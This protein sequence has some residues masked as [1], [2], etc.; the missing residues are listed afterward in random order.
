MNW[1]TWHEGMGMWGM[2]GGVMLLLLV[3]LVVA[4]VALLRGVGGAGDASR[5]RTPLEILQARYAS[6]QISRAEF[7]EKRRDLEA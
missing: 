3:L 7:E 4:V 1:G 5:R 2:G 6:G